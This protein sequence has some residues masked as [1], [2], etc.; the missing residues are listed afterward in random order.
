M[1]HNENCLKL[2]EYLI[3]KNINLANVNLSNRTALDYAVNITTCEP[4]DFL[5]KEIMKQKLTNICYDIAL[6]TSAINCESKI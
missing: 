2:V 4:L 3:A 1:R 6:I 5:L